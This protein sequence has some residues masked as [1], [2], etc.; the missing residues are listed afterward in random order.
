MSNVCCDAKPLPVE[1]LL[2]VELGRVVVDVVLR[3]L[4]L[5]LHV[6]IVRLERVEIVAHDTD[7]RL[8]AVERVTERQVIEAIEH[9]AGVDMLVLGYVDLFH[10]SRDV[11]RDAD[12][13]GFDIGVVGRH[14]LT[15]GDVPVGAG[16]QGERQQRKQRP[17][18]PALA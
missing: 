16:D 1:I 18:G 7:L 13:V 2:T 4:D 15:A 5:R 6:L 14:H 17:A 3:L 10:D 8:G 9:L 11:G 12:L